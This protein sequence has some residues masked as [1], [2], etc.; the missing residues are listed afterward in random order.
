MQQANVLGS[1]RT[2]WALQAMEPRGTC[3]SS[4]S[5]NPQPH[6]RTLDLEDGAGSGTALAGS[7]VF[8]VG[9]LCE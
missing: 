5:G 4:S 2:H 6:S 1:S 3:D 8:P 7:L 9:P